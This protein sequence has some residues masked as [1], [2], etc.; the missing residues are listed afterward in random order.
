M[1]TSPTKRSTPR[2]TP[3][4]KSTAAKAPPRAVAAA[5]KPLPK[6][7]KVSEPLV[8]E[9]E[10]KKVD[11]IDKVVERSGIKKK[12]AKPVVEAML[13][14]LSEALSGG[15]ELNLQ[16][17][18]KLRYNRIEEKANGRIIVC[19]IRQSMSTGP[20]EPKEPKDP[21]ADAAE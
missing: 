2:K 10:L 7:V 17:F 16:P 18:G 12:D 13:A 20:S 8:Q 19:K 3:A 9:P 1:A 11:L 14:E 15:R 5:K 21:L 6:V 4:H